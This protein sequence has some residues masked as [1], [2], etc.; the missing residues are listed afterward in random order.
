MS[1]QVKLLLHKNGAQ[2]LDAQIPPVVLA[3]AHT[4]GRDRESLEETD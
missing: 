3:Y 4:G 2:C 1:H